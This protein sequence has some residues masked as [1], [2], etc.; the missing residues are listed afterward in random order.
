M[1]MLRNSEIQRDS[2][3]RKKEAALARRHPRYFPS[4]L[5]VQ[6]ANWRRFRGADLWSPPGKHFSLQ[7]YAEGSVDAIIYCAE[8]ARPDLRIPADGLVP[9]THLGNER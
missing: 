2:T 8:T 4:Y 9:A 3:V 7:L 5:Y 1:Q 6:N